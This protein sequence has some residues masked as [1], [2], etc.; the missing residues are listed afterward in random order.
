MLDENGD[1]KATQPLVVGGG[2]GG[3]NALSLKDERLENAE[4]Q[5]VA[6]GPALAADQLAV[7][8][9]TVHAMR[10][11]PAGLPRAHGIHE[12]KAQMLLEIPIELRFLF[13]LERRRNRNK[14]VVAVDPQNRAT[15]PAHILTDL[16]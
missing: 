13:R 3:W 12:R 14:M 6:S 9:K 8:R 10:Q 1:V 11:L 5:L 16:D 2:K 15:R 7:H 4:W